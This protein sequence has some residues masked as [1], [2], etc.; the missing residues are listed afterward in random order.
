MK[1]LVVMMSLLFSM[2][3]MATGGFLCTAKIDTK[4]AQVDVQIS[5][6]TGRVSGN[7]LIADLQIGIDGLS[8]LQ[9]SIP[10][11]QIVGYWNQGAEL[12]INALN[13]DFEKS[14]VL[15]EYNIET[16]EGSLD[17]DFQGIKAVTTDLNCI[18][19]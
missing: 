7:P 17:F 12:K 8:D 18:F 1:T 6:N 4:D 2:N 14:Q 15:L 5:G 11:N 16:T 10:K 13:S 9:F 3:A 19:E